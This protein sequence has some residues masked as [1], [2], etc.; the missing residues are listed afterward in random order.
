MKGVRYPDKFRQHWQQV[1][2]VEVYLQ[3]QQHLELEVDL[4]QHQD[5]VVLV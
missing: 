1:A 3:Q 4:E 5:Q 2:K